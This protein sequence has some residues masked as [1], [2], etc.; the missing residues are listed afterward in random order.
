MS[1]P[2]RR[3]LMRDFKR[4]QN[5]PPQGVSGAPKDNDIMKWNAVIFGCAARRALRA[6]RRTV[7][8]AP[9]AAHRVCR[10]S[11]H[12][13]A[14]PNHTRCTAHDA[15]R[16]RTRSPRACARRRAWPLAAFL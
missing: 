12:T 6:A 3:R 5:D 11:A 16:L 9:R 4:L 14:E 7:A 15:R 1:T 10:G 13:H 2:A 8:A